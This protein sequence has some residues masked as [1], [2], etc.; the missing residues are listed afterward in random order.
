MLCLSRRRNE[1]FVIFV[2][3]QPLGTTQWTERRGDQIRFG[4]EADQRVRF[5]REELMERRDETPN[6]KA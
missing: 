4:F 3:G 5:L 1:R 2:D 6:T